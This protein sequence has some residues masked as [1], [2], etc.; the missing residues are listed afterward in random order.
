MSV[1]A[2]EMDDA[3]QQCLAENNKKMITPTLDSP[4]YGDLNNALQRAKDAMAVIVR[5]AVEQERERCAKVAETPISG[6]KCYECDCHGECPQD[7]I[8]AKIRGGQ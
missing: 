1:S 7:Y 5:E 4:I 6:E 8:A 3:L 2:E